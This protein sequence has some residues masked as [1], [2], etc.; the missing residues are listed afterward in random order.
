MELLALKEGLKLALVQ[1]L[2]RLEVCTDLCTD[3]QEIIDMLHHGDLLYD[4]VVY[5]CRSLLRS[6]GNPPVYHTYREQNRVSDLMAKQ[7]SE[8]DFF[9]RLHVF[10][11]PPVSVGIV[12]W[13]DF[14]RRSSSRPLSSNENINPNY[15]IFVPD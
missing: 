8:Q 14:T 1:N 15:Y 9:D 6:L 11:T 7:D 2:K 10:A 4:S 13:D 5:E 3:S 12:F